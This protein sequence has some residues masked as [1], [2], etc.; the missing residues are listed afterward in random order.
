MSEELLNQ[1]LNPDEIE[2]I[3]LEEYAKRD[4]KPPKAKRY[5][6]RVDKIRLVMAT[7]HPTGAEI[8]LKAGFSP[9]IYKLYLHKRN[10]QPVLVPPTEK[11]DLTQHG[12][13][14]F[15]TMPKD[16]TEGLTDAPGARRQFALPLADTDYL[17][18]RVDGWEAVQ[19]GQ[20]QWVL[21]HNWKLPTGYNNGQTSLAL[22]I[23]PNYS[24]SQ[25]D[26]VYVKPAL[27]RVD[28]KSINN[29]TPETICGE[30]WQR[31]SRH[32][33]GQNPWR[34]GVDDIASHL[35]LVDDWFRREFDK[36]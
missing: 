24:D 22:L 17:D 28:G 11:V 12:V 25:I 13:E 3:D 26:M 9:D 30:P 36:P 20:N 29:L 8:L 35:A 7:P 4:E 6:V 19:D 32:R 23:P 10:H 31:W 14:R 5:V 2:E 21:I 16:T 15:T 27:A 1:P 18:S 33:T 34:P